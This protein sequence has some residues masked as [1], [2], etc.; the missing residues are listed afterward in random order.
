M[1]IIE[2]I[3]STDRNAPFITR[4]K[5]QHMAPTPYG[6]PKLLPTDSVDGMIVYSDALGKENPRRGWEPTAEDL[7]AEDWGITS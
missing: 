3:E 1:N 5:W 4:E 7:I 2:A 6:A